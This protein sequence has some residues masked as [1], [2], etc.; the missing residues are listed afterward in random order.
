MAHALLSLAATTL[1]DTLD[2]WLWGGIPSTLDLKIIILGYCNIITSKKH[3]NYGCELF[4]LQM[5]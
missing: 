1:T 3:W 5:V 4:I 2:L